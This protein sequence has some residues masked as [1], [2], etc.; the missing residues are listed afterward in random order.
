LLR[1]T[2][3]SNAL[4]VAESTPVTHTLFTL[5]EGTKSVER[6]VGTPGL[7]DAEDIVDAPEHHALSKAL[8]I[9]TAPLT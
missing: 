1:K 2:P 7:Y 5:E 3:G 9:L 8:G 6:P 4:E